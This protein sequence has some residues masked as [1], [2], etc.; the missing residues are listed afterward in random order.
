[1]QELCQTYLLVLNKEVRVRD[2][3]A[4]IQPGE[5]KDVDAPGGSLRDA[6][7]PLPYKEPSATLLQLMGI[8]V[9]AGQRF[10]AISEL[11]TGEGTQNA[12]VG[13]T[14]ALLKEDL[15]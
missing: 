1:M 8:V 2:E 11:Q 15:K 14:I 3:A 6:F 7:Y 9:Q 5:F 12:A 13:T 10:A 4:P